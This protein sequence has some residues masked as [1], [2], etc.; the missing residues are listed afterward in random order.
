M[1]F[2][3]DPPL[4]N[5]PEMFF[6]QFS[7]FKILL[8]TLRASPFSNN[9]PPLLNSPEIFFISSRILKS[10]KVPFFPSYLFSDEGKKKIGRDWRHPY[11]WLVI[12]AT[13]FTFFLTFILHKL[14]QL[15]SNSRKKFYQVSNLKNR[16]VN[17]CGLLQMKAVQTI[18]SCIAHLK[19]GTFPSA[20]PEKGKL[21]SSLRL[22][23]VFN[24]F[25]ILEW[26]E[27]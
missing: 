16:I 3:L 2:Q 15:Y 11:N 22:I 23:N 7:H 9:S 8:R 17:L 19:L 10:N 1:G 21:L 14:C 27:A 12:T 4:L 24:F 26:G 13:S 20:Q 18:E 5:S 25:T 6:Y